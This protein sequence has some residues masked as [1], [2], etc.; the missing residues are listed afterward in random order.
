MHQGIYRL[1]I[2]DLRDSYKKTEHVTVGHAPFFLANTVL[3]IFL[4]QVFIFSKNQP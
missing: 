4:Y 3:Y 1:G 2:P